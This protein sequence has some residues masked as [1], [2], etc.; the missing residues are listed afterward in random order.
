[1]SL[2]AAKPQTCPQAVLHAVAAAEALTGYHI[3][4]PP[5][6]TTSA[7][8]AQSFLSSDPTAA[9]QEVIAT[10]AS[11]G[12]PS[13]DSVSRLCSFVLGLRSKAAQLAQPAF[14]SCQDGATLLQHTTAGLLS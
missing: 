14:Q 12:V 6:P 5:L 8:N 10:L 4:T 13:L 1:M 11:Y 9:I 7:D 2:C 3:P